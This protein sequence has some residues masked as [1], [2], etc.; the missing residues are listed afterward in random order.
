MLDQTI[1]LASARLQQLSVEHLP[2]LKVA[3]ARLAETYPGTHSDYLAH[4]GILEFHRDRLTRRIETHS[5]TSPL[6]WIEYDSQPSLVFGIEHS[7]YHSEHYHIPYYKLNPLFCFTEDDSRLH[8]CL[9]HLIDTFPEEQD[10]VITTRIETRQHALSYAMSTHGFT[11]VGTSVRMVLCPPAVE[12]FDA[13]TGYS[14]DGGTISP[15]HPDELEA[16]QAIGTA[17]HHHSHFFSERRFPAKTTRALFA[18]WLR[19]CADGLA[20]VILVARTGDRVDGFCSLLKN[21]GLE[22]YI[23]HSIGVIDFIA[24]A[25]HAQGKGLGTHLLNA[26]LAWFGGKHA[27]I[28]LR[29][30]ADN[31]N[32]IRFYERNGFRL[33]SSDLHYH[34][35]KHPSMSLIEVNHVRSHAE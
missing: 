1:E 30:M 12:P 17:S 10:A 7:G 21:T 16:V 5:S 20:D 3:F 14:Y 4:P 11:P 28:E 19:K 2:A 23:G 31:V 24:V 15:M 22:S 8:V 13:T 32:A 34:Y 9:P 25:Q 26:A 18:E 29:T 33:L 27:R 6:Y 35:W